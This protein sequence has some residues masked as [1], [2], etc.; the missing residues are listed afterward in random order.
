MLCSIVMNK[1]ASELLWDSVCI[2]RV[3]KNKNDC[4]ICLV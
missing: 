4:F 1:I 3:S 2:D